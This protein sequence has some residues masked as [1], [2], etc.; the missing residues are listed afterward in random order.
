MLGFK[1]IV[2]TDYIKFHKKI[3]ILRAYRN[4]I[5]KNIN[6]INSMFYGIAIKLQNNNL[7]D[8]QINKLKNI[9]NNNFH[10]NIYFLDFSNYR[11]NN[12]NRLL[13]YVDN[14]ISLTFDNL[15]FI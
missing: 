1:C 12:F 15:Y 10:I 14:D 4:I 3:D 8:N 9:I 13:N 2:Y 11:N 5:P 6:S 7:N